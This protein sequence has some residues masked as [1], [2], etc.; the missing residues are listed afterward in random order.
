MVGLQLFEFAIRWGFTSQVYSERSL[1]QAL[2]YLVLIIVPLC[3][4]EYRHSKTLDRILIL[5]T[6][7]Q[8]LAKVHVVK[9]EPLS[10]YAEMNM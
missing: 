2:F 10:W 3:F 1:L 4:V 9:N 7:F 6:L 8:V 5:P